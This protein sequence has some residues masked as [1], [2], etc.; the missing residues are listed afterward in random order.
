MIEDRGATLDIRYRMRSQPSTCYAEMMFSTSGT[1]LQKDKTFQVFADDLIIKPH[2]SFKPNDPNPY[3][4]AIFSWEYEYTRGQ[5]NTKIKIIRSDGLRFEAELTH[6]D[7]IIVHKNDFHC[8][9]SETD[10]R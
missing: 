6:D 8:F 7:H 9:V 10:E 2:D 5:L 3:P 1:G 4:L